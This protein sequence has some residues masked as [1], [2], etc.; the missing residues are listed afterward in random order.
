MPELLPFLKDLLSAPGLSGYEDPAASIIAARW[1]PLVHEISRSRIGSLHGFRHGTGVEPRP[2]IMIATHMDAI[3]LMVTGVVEGFLRVT[4]VGG[5]D[6][7]VLPGQLVTI[8]GRETLTGVVAQPSTRLLPPELGDGPVP[9]EHL[10]I[11]TGLGTKKC[12]RPGS[13]G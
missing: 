1:T 7:R 6:P 9:L 12:G 5:V 10:L 11:D 13:S 8:H 3:G 2:S 4:S